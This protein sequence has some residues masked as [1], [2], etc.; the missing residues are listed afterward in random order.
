MGHRRRELPRVGRFLS[1]AAQLK[2]VRLRVSITL[3]DPPDSGAREDRR[4][5]SVGSPGADPETLPPRPKHVHVATS[6]SERPDVGLPHSF[7]TRPR[8]HGQQGFLRRKKARL[9]EAHV[10]PINDLVDEI[11]RERGQFVPYVD[12]DSGGVRA[13]VLFVL[14]SPARPAAH[15][16][17][18]LSPDNDDGTAANLWQAYRASGL[19][20]NAA[21]HW[22]AVPWFIGNESRELN[23]SS[24]QVADGHSYLRRLLEMTEDVQV[25]VAMG[26]P[27]QASL[28]RLESDLEQRGI[29]LI[30]CIHPSP[31][32]QRSRGPPTGDQR[33]HQRAGG[34]RSSRQQVDERLATGNAVGSSYRGEDDPGWMSARGAHQSRSGQCL[35]PYEVTS[36]RAR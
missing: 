24:A 13:R 32:K 17:G 14:E 29:R 10:A 31:R 28:R 36:R 33:V 7:S 16:S 3:A 11:R 8:M 25:V 15:G 1:R 34:A 5:D 9:K 22:N 23:V 19:P 4:R 27:A 21:V 12:P 2:R 35:H 30:D 18:M 20:R 6:P 26:K